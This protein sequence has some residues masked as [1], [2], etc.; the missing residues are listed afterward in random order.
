MKRTV[1]VT[2]TKEFEIE[3]PDEMLTDEEIDSF[4]ENMF[5]VDGVDDLF[6]YAAKQIA[7][8]DTG[9]VEG[10]GNLWYMENYAEAETEFV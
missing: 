10:L 5:E 2:I 8:Y 7:L 4:T 9:N 1:M 6:S 3:I